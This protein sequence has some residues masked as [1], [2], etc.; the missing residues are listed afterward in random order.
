MAEFIRLGFNYPESGR[1]KNLGL[2]QRLAAFLALDEVKEAGGILGRKVELVIGNTA[3]EPERGATN[4]EELILEEN[5]DI[6]FGGASSAVTIASGKVAKKLGRP[7]FGTTTSANAT[8][9]TKKHPDALPE[10]THP[11]FQRG[12]G[13]C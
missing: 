6:V 12:F 13:S 11:G 9:D 8:T 3:G 10:S 2:Q 7:Y 1:N 4:T 5:V